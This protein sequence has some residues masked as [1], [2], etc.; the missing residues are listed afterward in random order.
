MQTTAATGSPEMAD[1]ETMM[2]QFQTG[3][4][5]QNRPPHFAAV[6]L[7]N[8]INCE[9]SMSL[10]HYCPTEKNAIRN[11]STSRAHWS[12]VFAFIKCLVLMKNKASDATKNILS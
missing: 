2:K 10:T 4:H 6:F 8:F 7:E 12:S 9:I 11:I 3:Y 5:V 1:T